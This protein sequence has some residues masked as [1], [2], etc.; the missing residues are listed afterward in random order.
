MMRDK[1]VLESLTA[2]LR[3]EHA[4]PLTDEVVAAFL[5]LP[6][7]VD[8]EGIGRMRA[9]IAV[10]ALAEIHQAPARKI[11]GGRSFGE[12]VQ[13]ARER[14][15]LTR[16]AIAAAVQK[17]VPFVERV[18]TGRASPFK[19]DPRDISEIVCLFRLHIDGLAQLL[20]NTAASA[21]KN[22]RGMDRRPGMGPA[23]T[24]L[25]DPNSEVSADYRGAPGGGEAD[26]LLNSVRDDL[27]RRQATHLLE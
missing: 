16:E 6:V 23:F 22:M 13:A 11:E 12:W 21:A 15:R 5:S 24:G 27:R 7:E 8:P 25:M 20:A 10:A 4:P 19:L 14:A 1:D 18:E 17:D 9:G 3:S 26:K 2:L